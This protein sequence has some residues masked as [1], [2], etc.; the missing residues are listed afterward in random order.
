MEQLRV[1][2]THPV[3]IAAWRFL[4]E[5]AAMGPSFLNLA[6]RSDHTERLCRTIDSLG[7]RESVQV[8]LRAV[9]LITHWDL[10]PIDLGERQVFSSLALGCT[11]ATSSLISVD[12]VRDCVEVGVPW[13]LR[14]MFVGMLRHAAARDVSPY[15]NVEEALVSE[16]NEIVS[17]FVAVWSWRAGGLVMGP[18]P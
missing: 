15:E 7:P 10:G 9:P 1:D 16:G 13:C 18:E 4:R 17:G 6:V 3:R 12:I 14:S 11:S 5:G 2:S 8:A